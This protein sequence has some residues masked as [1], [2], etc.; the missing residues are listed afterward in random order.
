MGKGKVIFIKNA[1]LLTVTSLLL[2]LVG[3]VFRVWLANAVGAEGM[4]L[5]QQ[6]FSLYA[7]VSV[8]ASAG[9]G[10]AVTRLISEEITLGCRRGV[11]LILLRSMA[12]TTAVAVFSGGALWLGSDKVAVYI[13]SDMRAADS[14]KMMTL[15]LPFMAISA[16]LKGYFFARKKAGPNS[17]SQIIEQA[18]R[19]SAIFYIFTVYN[20]DAETA[21]AA[22]FIGDAIAE[23]S[24]SL[25][26]ALRYKFDRKRLLL[27]SGRAR[28]PYKISRELLRII[29]PI[30]GGRYLNSFLRTVENIIVPVNLTKFGMSREAALSSFGGIKGMA[31]PLLLF[32][33]GLLS[34]VTSLLVP[35]M[36]EAAA[37]GHKARIRYAAERSVTLTMLSSIPFA[38]L[39]FFAAEPFSQ[40]IY[41]DSS[42][43]AVVQ[44]LAPLVPF[45]YIDSV[46]DALLKALDKQSAT[47]RHALLDSLGR[48]AAILVLLSRFGECGFIAVMYGSNLFTSLLNL[49]LLLK[50]S[51]AK[52]SIIQK[53]LLPLLAALVGGIAAKGITGALRVSGLVYIILITFGIALTYLPTV[54]AL[55]LHKGCK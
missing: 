43:G 19:I 8:F 52:I 31:L 27:L 16:V 51:G 49:R 4:G 6:I 42:V 28:P 48:I 3:M 20:T 32:P 47:F 25:Y 45:M 12:L 22:V 54:F 36:S 17:S 18:V 24:S 30:V 14:L 9:V 55:R 37:A 39:F 53:V 2:R 5:Y 10:L 38:V 1:L 21:C 11:E 40:L 33:A 34:S 35:E 50:E 15:S 41:K 46:S 29:S 23:L 13:I 7:F 44:K 26:L